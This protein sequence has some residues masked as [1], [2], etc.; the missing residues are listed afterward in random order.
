[1]P[2]FW[3]EK[4]KIHYLKLEQPYYDDV[5]YGYKTFEIRKNDRDFKVGDL[6]SLHEYSHKLQ[7]YTNSWIGVV[8]KYISDYAQKDGYVVLGIEK[9]TDEQHFGETSNEISGGMTITINN[10]DGLYHD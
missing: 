5:L 10:E 6:L 1:M 3:Q 4:H 7:T 2:S 8:I 9:I